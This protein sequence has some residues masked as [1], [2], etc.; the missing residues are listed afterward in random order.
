MF[1]PV[2]GNVTALLSEANLTYGLI[3]CE[4]L[5]CYYLKLQAEV[6]MILG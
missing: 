3:I 2:V 6:Y 5:C 4:K 1:V